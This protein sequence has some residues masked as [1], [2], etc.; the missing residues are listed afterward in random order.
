MSNHGDRATQDL[1]VPSTVARLNYFFGQLLTQRDLLAEQRFHLLLQRLMQRETL[2]TGTVAGLRVDAPPEASARG[3]FVRAGLALDPAG[4]ELVLATDICIHVADEAL[5]AATAGLEGDDFA[6]LA[7][8]LADTWDAAIDETD[9]T[10]LAAELKALG[11]IASAEA[12]ALREALDRVEPPEDLVLEPGTTLRDHLLDALVGT[13]YVGVRYHERGAEPAPATLD[14]SCGGDVRCFPTRINEGVTLVIQPAPFPSIADPYADV[15]VAL[16]A[17]FGAEETTTPPDEELPFLHRCRRCLCDHLL[18][19]WRG[20]PTADDPCQTQVLPI[21]P[22]AFVRWDRFA[23]PGGTSRI[24]DIDNCAIRPLAPG[25]PAV[26]ALLEAITS[27][28]SPGPRA[29]YLVALEPAHRGELE[30]AAGARSARV[31]ARASMPVAAPGTAGWELDLYPADGSAVRRFSPANPPA[32]LF[33]VSLAIEDDVQVALRFE[34]L[35][36]TQALAMPA[37]T[38]AWRINL[39]GGELAAQVTGVLLDGEPAPVLA[40]PSG[41]GRP[42]GVFEAR[43]FVRP[44]G[45]N[46]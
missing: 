14:A 18:G 30:V 25:V 27:C 4:R 26:R 12:V 7:G 39:P 29:P 41:D 8:S 6:S 40:V 9:L 11:V 43:F 44:P 20:V 45:G 31:V 3:V 33:A 16:D 36:P 38:Y 34:A 21:V 13:T 46:V 24:I 35:A 19:A 5:T 22:L 10:A 15:R 23:R 42:G 2:G 1:A 17:C 28:T 32:D 37:G